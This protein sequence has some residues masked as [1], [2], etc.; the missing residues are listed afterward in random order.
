MP[1]SGAELWIE[2][3]GHVVVYDVQGGFHRRLQL[4]SI[5]LAKTG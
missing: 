5:H 3:G 1:L 2:V 4:C